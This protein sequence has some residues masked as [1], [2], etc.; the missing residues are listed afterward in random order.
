MVALT[1]LIKELK[2]NS[3]EH[4]RES[5]RKFFKEKVEIYGIKTA[6]VSNIAKRYFGEIKDHTKSEIFVLCEELLA[7]GIMEESFVA[8]SWSYA[9]KKQYAEKDFFIFEKWLDKY[10]NNWAT[11]DTLCNHTIGEF[12]DR[13]P[14]YR[15]NLKEWTKSKNRW[16]KRGSAV[17]LIV[18]A[19]RGKFLKDILE[20][21]DRLLLDKDDLVQKGYGWLLKAASQANE[22][23]VFDYVMSNRKNMPRTALRYAIEKMPKDLKEK[24]MRK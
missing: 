19:K 7:S 13:Y 24:A 4:T 6:T 10:V 18:P 3:D 21:A 23:A 1:E 11:C 5:A 22:R 2:Q 17:T 20:I 12:V 16:I 14:K 8:C 15:E 9:V